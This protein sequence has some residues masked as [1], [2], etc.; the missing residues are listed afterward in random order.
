MGCRAPLCDNQG[1][2]HFAFC[3]IYYSTTMYIHSYTHVARTDSSE[4]PVRVAALLI[5][6]SQVSNLAPIVDRQT[7]QI[8]TPMALRRM[9]TVEALD[10]HDE[11]DDRCY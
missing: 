4:H 10:Q 2:F 6:K 9:M 3:T 11:E 1:S 7:A 5:D 8:P